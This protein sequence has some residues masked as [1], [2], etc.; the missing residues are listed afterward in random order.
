MYNMSI[1]RVGA[2]QINTAVILGGLL[3][4]KEHSRYTAY[5]LGPLV[6]FLEHLASALNKQASKR[7]GSDI[8]DAITTV[9]DAFLIFGF[10]HEDWAPI[11]TYVGMFVLFF[12]G[13]GLSFL[14]KFIMVKSWHVDEKIFE[15]TKRGPYLI[16]I[17]RS[18]GLGMTQTG[19]F[20]A[21]LEYGLEDVKA[22]GVSCVVLTLGLYA[23]PFENMQAAK[24]SMTARHFGM[25]TGCALMSFL[26]LRGGV[27][28]DEGGVEGGSATQ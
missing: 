18:V 19:V 7:G 22:F 21:A 11:A 17:S 15:D 25:A 16:L 1:R 13:L 3:C 6:W 5:S 2:A 8:P 9:L 14:T 10:L 23:L 28:N 24:L 20:M 26:M 12:F 27:R 4:T